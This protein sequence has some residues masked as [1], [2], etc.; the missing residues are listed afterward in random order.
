[1]NNAGIYRDEEEEHLNP[2]QKHRPADP[3]SQAPGVVATFNVFDVGK[4]GHNQRRE[5]RSK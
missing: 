3:V 2:A 5:G 4:R 1:M